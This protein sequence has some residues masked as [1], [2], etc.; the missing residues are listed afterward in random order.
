M[1]IYNIYGATD[2]MENIRWKCFSHRP[3][4]GIEGVYILF[5]TS[6][7]SLEEKI[8]KKLKT[9]KKNKPVALYYIQWR[10]CR[11]KK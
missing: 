7:K 3:W 4:R 10:R 8:E 5:T 2:K 1:I 9:H 11:A 6:T